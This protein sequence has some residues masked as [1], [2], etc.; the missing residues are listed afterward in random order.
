M[1]DAAPK[2]KS[3]KKLLVIV[4][5]LVVVLALAGAGAMFFL[6]KKNAGIDED[7]EEG[8]AETSHSAPAHD[9][10]N[11][12]TFLPIDNLVVNLADPGGERFAQVG[13]TFQ[14]ADA[15]SADELKTNLPRVRSAVLMLVSSRSSEELLSREGKEKM[16][17]AIA[18]E[19]SRTFGIEPEDEE[20]EE[21]PAAKKK[22]GKKKRAPESPVQAVL[23]SSFIVQ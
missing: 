23:F 20:A 22:K 11:P 9:K 13:I 3:K 5:V 12:P 18:A 6:K 19:A 10:K 7:G 17:K 14:M 2:P 15:H 4:G 16:A 8:A 1:S 21:D